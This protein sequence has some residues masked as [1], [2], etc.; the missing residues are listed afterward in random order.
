[1][2][3]RYHM[4]ARMLRRRILLIHPRTRQRKKK[5][6]KSGRTAGDSSISLRFA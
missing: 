3:F 2:I 4:H 6:E 1:M 5:G